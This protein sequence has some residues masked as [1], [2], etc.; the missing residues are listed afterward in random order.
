[1]ARVTIA[2]VFHADD[3]AADEILE[4]IRGLYNIDLVHVQQSYGKLWIKKGDAP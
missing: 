2:V 1:M 4:T 3:D